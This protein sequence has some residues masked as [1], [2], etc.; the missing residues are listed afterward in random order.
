VIRDL[1]TVYSIGY[2]PSKKERDGAWRTVSV[3][4]KGHPELA[5]RTKHGYYAKAS[6]K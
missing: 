4:L 1:G 6:V 5:A 3:R 2:Q